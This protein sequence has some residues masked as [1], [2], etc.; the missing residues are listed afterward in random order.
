MLCGGRWSTATGTAEVSDP[1]TG[2]VVAEIAQ[3]GEAE[4]EA[5]LTAAARAVAG[6]RWP[7]AERAATLGVAANALSRAREQFAELIAAE[8]VKTIR[9]ARVEV[10]RAVHTLRLSAASVS[11]PGQAAPLAIDGPGTAG[12]RGQVHLRPVGVVAA[13]TPYNDPLNLVVHKVGPAL[14]VGNAVIVKPDERT[15]LTALLL[16]RL[17]VDCGVPPGRLSVLPAGARVASRLV[18]DPR[19]RFVSF[20]GGR[21]TGVLVHQA[22]GVKPSLMELGGICPT[23]LLDDADLDVAVPDIIA[24]AYGAAGQ[25]CLHVQRV[26]IHRSLYDTARDRLVAA[27]E[28]VLGGPK[29]REDSDM[30]PLI[31]APAQQRIARLVQQ[32]QTVA[33]RLLT[34]G[35]TDG[36]RYLP[37]LLEAVPEE[38]DLA[39]EEIFGPVTSIEPFDTLDAAIAM[40]NRN[41]GEIQA[42]VFTARRDAIDV[43]ADMLDFGGVVIG[44]TSDHRSDALPFGGTGGAGIGREGVNYAA[45]AMTEL[46]SLLTAPPLDPCHGI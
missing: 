23:L 30:G 40:A 4:L 32:A 21:V 10:A 29:T 15:P 19:V 31:D 39:R 41:A 38:A 44:G 34:G 35:A 18:A 3:A 7:G 24:G 14:A 45:A 11:A 20:T 8:G 37:T 33:A 28:A 13:I 42:G 9:E 1:D 17:L 36:P 2:G 27:A 6:P 26:L 25:N 16:A 43:L 5:A 46:R 12:W 22:A